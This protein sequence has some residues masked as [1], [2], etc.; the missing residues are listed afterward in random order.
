MTVSE[1]LGAALTARRWCG[2][3]EPILWATWQVDKR[4]Q[5][6]GL[7][8]DGRPKKGLGATLGDAASSAAG[9]VAVGALTMVFGGGDSSSGPGTTQ[10][11]RDLTIVGSGQECAAMNLI[12]TRYPA[13]HVGFDMLWVL[14]PQRL[15]VLVP[16]MLEDSEIPAH[17]T[18]SETFSE[19]GRILVGKE[20]EQFGWNT[21][22]EPISS[23]PVT[24]WFEI[25]LH[26]V[27][28]CR[29]VGEKKDSHRYCGLQF[30]D[31]SGFVLNARNPAD[32]Q[33]M[34]DALNYQRG[35]RG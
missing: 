14:T 21:P 16:P 27:V 19:M 23:K 24:T 33:T 1:K 20:T 18:L 12:N 9:A 35:I 32:A 26:D 31:G 29:T 7:D 34:V 17:P 2:P 11:G 25:A 30:A 4:Y 13:G 5:V 28:D 3:G 15:A 22:G 6:K 10:R 8:E